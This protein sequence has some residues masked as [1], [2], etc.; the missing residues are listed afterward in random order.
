MALFAA[1]GRDRT[2]GAAI[3]LNNWAVA[4]QGAGQM[5]HAAELSRRAVALAREVDPERGAPPTALWSLASSLSL[6]GRREEALAAVDEAVTKVRSAGSPW[7]HIWALATAARVAVEAGELDLADQ[8]LSELEAMMRELKNPQVSQQAGVERTEARVALEHG[9]GRGATTYAEHALAR[10]EAAKRPT[11]E[12]L[13]VLLVLARARYTS[14]DFAGARAAAERA[15]TMARDR[16][17][18]FSSS[19]ELGVA[20]LELG[21]AEGGAGDVVAARRTVEEAVSLLRAADGQSGPDTVRATALQ[22]DL[23]TK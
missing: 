4:T 7:Q 1:Q 18:G 14:G 23:T 9:D 8:R 21:A 13:P 3:C 11:R 10:L 6:V 20:T 15:R 22:R 19:H 16:L 12:V 17:G 2:Q 5:Q